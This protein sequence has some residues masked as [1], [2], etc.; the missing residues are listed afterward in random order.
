MSKA[1]KLIAAFGFV[2]AVAAC[3][4]GQTDDEYVVAPEP[5]TVEPTYTGK[6]K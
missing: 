3:T 4:S 6:Y 2:A 5:I 1:I